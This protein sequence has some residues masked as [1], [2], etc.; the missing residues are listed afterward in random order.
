MDK[1]L[2]GSDFPICNPAMNLKAVLFE[3]LTDAE[4]KAVFAGN[5]KR[6]I[7]TVNLSD[8]LTPVSTPDLITQSLKIILVRP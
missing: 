5:F 2:F 6:P 7:R 3:H 1:I 8:A 4:L